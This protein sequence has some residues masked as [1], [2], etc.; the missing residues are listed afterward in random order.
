MFIGCKIRI[1][2]YFIFLEL[3]YLS[4]KAWS[5][6]F[7]HGSIGGVEHSLVDGAVVRVILDFL[8][9]FSDHVTWTLCLLGTAAGTA[10]HL[11]LISNYNCTAFSWDEITEEKI[12]NK[13]QHREE[14]LVTEQFEFISNPVFDYLISFQNIFQLCQTLLKSIFHQLSLKLT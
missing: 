9:L 10:E 4:V 12:R 8:V 6:N 3:G 11:F 1:C 2:E 14:S 13:K 5:I 7:D